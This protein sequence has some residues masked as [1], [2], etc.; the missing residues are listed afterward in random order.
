MQDGT[1]QIIDQ[2]IIQIVNGLGIRVITAVAADDAV[3]GHH[4]NRAGLGCEP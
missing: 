4:P 2:V 1:E 3:I